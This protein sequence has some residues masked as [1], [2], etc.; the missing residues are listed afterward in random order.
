MKSLL[1]GLVEYWPGDEAPT[2]GSNFRGALGKLTLSDL[3]HTAVGINAG[4]VFKERGTIAADLDYFEHTDDALL[5]PGDTDFCFCMWY[6][7]MTHVA[8]TQTIFSKSQTGAANLQYQAVVDTNDKIEWL[9]SGNGA[10][11]TTL[12]CNNL[13]ALSADSSPDGA[14]FLMFF[15]DSVNNIIGVK[16]CK[17]ILAGNTYGILDSAAHAT[18]VFTGIRP[19]QIG[20]INASA[21]YYGNGK[22]CE[23]GFWNRILTEQEFAYLWNNGRGRTFPFWDRRYREG[24]RGHVPMFGKRRNRILGVG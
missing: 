9:V 19:F 3:T 20:A 13:G 14:Y 24:I 12:V 11:W 16:S 5:N 1:S 18:G 4:K 8:G 22:Y 15:H 23:I 2:G 6:N 21:G 7:F 17:S 10:A